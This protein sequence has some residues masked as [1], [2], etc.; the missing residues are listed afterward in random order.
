MNNYPA[1]WKL[2]GHGYMLLYRFGKEFANQQGPAFLKGKASPGFGSVMLVNYE[3]SNCGPYGELL[4]I[5]GKYRYNNEKKHTI[6]KIFVSSQD[7]VENGRANWGIPKELAQFTFEP[8]SKNVEK[9]TVKN[10]NLP[11]SIPIFEATFKSSGVPFPVNTN[12]LP[13]PLLQHLDD[14]E[15]HTTFSGKGT[16]R[17]A[18]MNDIK[19]NEKMFPDLTAF[20][21]IAV[22]RIAPFE[23]TFPI[24]KIR[25]L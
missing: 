21:P 3:T 23:I 8:L 4:L 19:I 9:V 25:R 14:Q 1:P 15:Y 5:P 16:G 24:A 12:L 13:F 6:S 18:T 7:S 22:I 2:T 10:G 17:L 11:D 20:K